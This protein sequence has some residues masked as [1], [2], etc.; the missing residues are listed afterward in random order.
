MVTASSCTKD[1]E[2]PFDNPDNLPPDDTTGI[3][4]ADP[5]SFVGLHQNIFK[6]TC[7]N[8]GCH[9]GTFEP[10]FRTIESSYNTLVYHSVVKNDPNGSYQYRVKPGSL[11]ESI[12]WLRL[13]QDIDGFSGIMPLDADYNPESTWNANEAEHLSNI[14][15][16][17]TNGALDMFGNP[18]N[19]NDQQPGIYG[20]YATADGSPCEVSDRIYIP[21]GSNQI[22]VWFALN[23]K[24]TAPQ[25]YDYTKVKMSGRID[26]VD[27]LMTEYQLQTL[28]AA[29]THDGFLG[30]PVDYQHKFDFNASG[31]QADSTYYLRVFV[32]DPMQAD[33]TQIP[34]ESSQF[35][36]KKLFSWQFVN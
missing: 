6:P 14:S 28:G 25:N 24:E 30:D 2:N 3:V 15:E 26:F 34:Q 7:A 20:I 16:W 19:N 23:D 32:K 9:D 4:D 36:I 18:P 13:N 8:S 1:S 17:I 12:M 29:Q 33:T 21:L 10:D 11:S 35:Y 5:T 27:T 31:F 22:S